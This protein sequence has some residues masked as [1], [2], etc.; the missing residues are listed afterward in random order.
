MPYPFF[1]SFIGLIALTDI[2]YDARRKG[3]LVL[4]IN[5]NLEIQRSMK[6]F[7][8]TNDVSNHEIDLNEYMMQGGEIP[9][10]DVST[11]EEDNMVGIEGEDDATH[12]NHS[13]GSFKS[14]DS[15]RDSKNI[16]SYKNDAD[17]IYYGD[18]EMDVE[19]GSE[20]KGAEESS[21]SEKRI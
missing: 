1:L 10:N 14:K 20:S 5:G 6:K 13:P 19:K 18:V 7:G 21:T 2:F 12:S 11:S 3:I 4:A 9:F 16:D 15:R 17:A 8:L